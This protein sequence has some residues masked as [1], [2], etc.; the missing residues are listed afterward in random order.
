VRN[1]VFG[2]VGTTI[3]F[4]VGP[5]DAEVLETVFKPQFLAADLVNLAFAQVYLTLMIDGVGSRP[6]SATTL[7]PIEPPR[8]SY[9]DQIIQHSRATYGGARKTV[10]EKISDYSSEL[11]EKEHS[12][13]TGEKKGTGTR[14]AVRKDTSRTPYSPTRSA[15]PAR[16]MSPHTKPVSS[17]QDLVV[18]TQTKSDR[19]SEKKRTSMPKSDTKTDGE[20]LKELRSTLS[21][22]A[23][24][25][26]KKKFSVKKTKPIPV[27]PSKKQFTKKSPDKTI[28]KGSDKAEK[29]NEVPED[30]LKKLLDVEEK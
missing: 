30:V 10:E 27:T 23:G 18:G 7:A 16:P 2:N 12:K 21:R 24:G 9:R 29:K 17:L 22:I 14:P 20:H 5:F 25:A 3:T 11:S 26:S 15:S 13:Q 8:L 19:E 1:A 6:F 28:E 4:R